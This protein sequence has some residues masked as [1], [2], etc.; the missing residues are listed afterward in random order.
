MDAT[1]I[2][3][4][5]FVA[6][7]QVQGV[8]FRPFVYRLAQEEGLTGAVGNTSEG[9]RMEVQGALQAV[10]RFGRRLRTELPPLARLVALAEEELEPLPGEAA[11]VIVPSS[12]HAGHSVL[13][14]PDMGVCPD[15]LAEMRDAANR[16]YRYPFTNC[17][18][19]GPRYTITRSIPYDRAVTSMSCFPLCPECAA[20]YGN[21]GDRRFHAQPI[22]CP[23]CGPRLWFVD[24]AAAA[25]GHTVPAEASQHEALAR[26]AHIL[27]TGGILALK[28]LGGFQLACDAR[29]AQALRELRRRKARPHKPLALMAADLTAVRSLCRLTPE[30][31]ALLQSPEKPIVLCPC[32]PGVLPREVA[33]D[34]RSVGLMLP[35][36]PLHAVLFDLLQERMELPPVLV[37]TSA[38]ASGEPICLGNREALARLRGLA[39]AWL[40]H[41]RD[42]LARV[43]DSVLAVT[44]IPPRPAV[45]RSARAGLARP[46]VSGNDAAGGEAGCRGVEPLFF[47]RARGYVPRPVFLPD[48]GPAVLGA[49]AELKGTLCL[50]RGREA[51]VSQHIGD[52]ENPATLGFYEEAAAHLEKLLEVRPKA[53]VCDLHPDFLSTRHAEARAAQDGLPLWRLQHHAAHAAS[54]LAENRQY[55]PALALCLDGTGLGQD[56]SIWGGELLRM[57]LR[58]A[59]WSRLG[60][61]SPFALPGGEA[62]IREP[63]RI[64]LGLQRQG[65]FSGLSPWEREYAA[66]ATAVEEMLLR[67]VNC[68][69]T[70]SCGR[71]F[72]AVAAQLG[73]C[74]ATSYEGQAAIRLEAAAQE[75]ALQ[76]EAPWPVAIRERDGLLELDSAALF[77]QVLEEQKAG[78]A[79]QG[80]AARF[81]LSMAQGFAALAA[82]AA[83]AAGLDSVGLS[84]GVLQN[85]ILARLLPEALADLGLVPL[86]HHELPPGDGGLSLGQAVWGRC[87]L[88]RS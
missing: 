47:R 52:L 75:T 30:H 26:A 25:S 4:R 61:L 33:P 49:G 44:P 18:N 56:G 51:F 11:F 60:R 5:A 78:C 67:G 86:T 81:H 69:Q 72:D 66:A 39:D 46:G 28:G 6:A 36:T 64:A 71:L 77:A 48:D 79:P 17:T 82:A 3:R 70:S 55:A 65:H 76:T 57:D 63:W 59:Q 42:I 9:V 84:G 68:P 19:C 43:D 85:A 23:V 1:Q 45:A 27:L 87:L 74:L 20:E 21:P 38:N 16:R 29:N 34:T 32:L 10:A 50:T 58:T 40:L 31:Q 62:A 37:M 22:A 88:R 12:G 54:V 14:S 2:T 83:D 7:G 15:C 41:D 35:Y 73:L 13:V 8:G 80:I 24:A 53:V